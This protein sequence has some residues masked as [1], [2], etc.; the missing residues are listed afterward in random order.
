[1]VPRFVTEALHFS[2]DLARNLVTKQPVPLNN[3]DNISTK[4]YMNIEKNC[5]NFKLCNATLETIIK[6]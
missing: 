1:M 2:S 6:L 4:Y 3:F 5:H